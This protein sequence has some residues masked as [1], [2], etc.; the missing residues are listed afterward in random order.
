MA[1]AKA[2]TAMNNRAREEPWDILKAGAP[3]SCGVSEAILF[4]EINIARARR[5]TKHGGVVTAGEA[6]L[7]VGHIS[8]HS[9]IDRLKGMR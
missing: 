7:A 8:S 3:G 5:D 9:R 1:T 6:W 4:L 2:E